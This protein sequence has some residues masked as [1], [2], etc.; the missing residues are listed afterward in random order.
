VAAL[1]YGV[2]LERKL[3]ELRESQAGFAKAV[4]E[5]DQAAARAEAGLQALKVMTEV[6]R[7]EL[8]DRSTPRAV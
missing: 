2:R 8:A 7:E 5:L 3:R 6:A 1:A 4:Q